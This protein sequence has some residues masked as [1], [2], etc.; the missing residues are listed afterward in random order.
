[1]TVIEDHLEAAVLPVLRLHNVSPSRFCADPLLT[2]GT[3]LRYDIGREWKQLYHPL[4]YSLVHK[5]RRGKLPELNGNP[6]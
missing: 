4:R 1:M 3:E 2:S 5:I 6:C